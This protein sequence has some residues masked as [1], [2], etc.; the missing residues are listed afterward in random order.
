[1]AAVAAG[2]I[3][4]LVAHWM[5]NKEPPFDVCELDIR[6]FIGLHNNRKFLK[7][8][9]KEVPGKLLAQN[10]LCCPTVSLMSSSKKK[11]L[12]FIRNPQDVI[13]R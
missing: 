1:M 6:R 3:G 8:R 11:F 5:V 12:S 13:T 7:D 2:G 10:H 4:H 9:I